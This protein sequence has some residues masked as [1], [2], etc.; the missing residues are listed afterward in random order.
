MSK[1]LA[2]TLV[3]AFLMASCI[4]MPLPVKAV[5]NTI[6]VPD[7]YSTITAAIANANTGD[8]IFIRAGLYEGPINQTILIDK[9]LSIVGENAET[10]IIELYPAYE[11]TWII[12]Q[13]F[14]SYTNAITIETND[15]KLSN[16]TIIIAPGGNIWANGDRIQITGNNITTGSTQTGL[17]INGSQCNITDNISR[18]GFINLQGS[19]NSLVQNYVYKVILEF[20]DWNKICLNQIT[21][22]QFNSSNYNTVYGNNVDIKEATYNSIGVYNSAHNIFQSNQIKSGLFGVNL[23]LESGAKNNTFYHNAFVGEGYHVIIDEASNSNFWDDSNEGNFWENYNGTDSNGDGIGDTPYVI[24]G[25][26]VDNYPLMEPYNVEND[27]VVLPPP[28]PFPTVLAAAA[29]VAA[30]VGVCL[31]VYFK[32]RKH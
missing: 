8:V 30:A 7:D 18:F 15:V 5:F 2:F 28:E 12:T 1:S 26:N 3:L 20:A 23:R 27:A 14:Y 11:L 13:P 24:N 4:S 31:I 25:A 10:T 32:K 16:L 6:T 19:S 21:H 22:L 9:P 29:L 17:L